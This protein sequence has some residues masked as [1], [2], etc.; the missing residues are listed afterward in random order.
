MIRWERAKTRWHDP[1]SRRI[2]DRE[3]AVLDPRIRATLTAMEKM[4]E[5]T[6]QAKRDCG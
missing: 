6:D 5:I 4:A 3:L 2:E 1:V